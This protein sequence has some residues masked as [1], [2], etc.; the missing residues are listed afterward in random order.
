MSEEQ[1][2]KYIHVYRKLR[3]LIEEGY[4][5]IGS[6]LPPESNLVETYQASRITIR[7]ALGLLVH[8]GFVQSKR[9]SGHRVVSN[10]VISSSCFTSF[11]EMVLA[12]GMQPSTQII[13]IKTVLAR[14]FINQ[15]LPTGIKD[16]EKLVLVERLRLV[17]R[18]PKI[19]MR[20][21]IPKRL[22]P[23]L[24]EEDF[25]CNGREQ[26]ILSLL[27]RKYGLSI[28][29]GSEEIRPVLPNERIADLLQIPPDRPIIRHFCAVFSRTETLIMY[30][31]SFRVDVLFFELNGA[32][33]KLQMKL[34]QSL[35][36]IVYESS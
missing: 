15:T 19:V 10:R 4:A 29:Y 2:P 25:A 17:D 23:G 28:D 3:Q 22:V 30:E 13:Q 7:K 27:Q 35:E 16:N 11:T 31:E 8:E 21:W 14:S 12:A 20:A 9:G 26:S 6:K 24:K 34:N 33:R 32:E 18:I 5:P 1:T 36:S